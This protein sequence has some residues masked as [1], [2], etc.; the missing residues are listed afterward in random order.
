MLERIL[1]YGSI[2]LIIIGFVWLIRSANKQA[3]EKGF[4]NK[5]R[6]R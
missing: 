5:D 4:D 2:A 3:K 1:V 6:R